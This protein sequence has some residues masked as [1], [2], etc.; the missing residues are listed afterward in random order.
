M[1]ELSKTK[2]VS[3]A[4]FG[5]ILVFV[6]FILN[7]TITKLV[8]L[9]EEFERIQTST[10]CED[11]KFYY[12]IDNK[13]IY[14]YCLDSI[15]VN[16]QEGYIEL[17]DMFKDGSIT[18]ESLTEKMELKSDFKDGGSVLYTNDANDLALLKCNTLEGNKDIYIGPK[19]MEYEPSFCKNRYPI[20]EEKDF[21][22][23]YHIYN[24][25]PHND[26]N[27]KYITVFEP[28]GLEVETVLV[29]ARLVKGL[30]NDKNYK[31]SFTSSK[32]PFESTIKTVF[33]NSE[34]KKITLYKN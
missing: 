24:V 3:L 15:Q 2:K 9:D 33:D 25:V 10:S 27:Y 30:K 18:I 7:D 29:E 21:D 1:K 28:N 13:S 20:I 5:I 31:F 6:G 14:T 4:L 8:K 34:L 32:V 16:T 19:D 23:I 22:I 11:T 17:K 26:P 12:A